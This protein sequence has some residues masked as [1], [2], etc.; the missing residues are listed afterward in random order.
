MTDDTEEAGARTELG[1]VAAAAADTRFA[2]GE[3]QSHDFRSHTDAEVDIERAT[4]EG[5]PVA[6]HDPELEGTFQA[7][8]EEGTLRLRRSLPTLLAT[9]LVGGI[10]LSI[11]VI[12]LIVVEHETGSTLLAALAFTI[13]F[14]ALTLAR[15][16]LFTE[17]FL[18]PVT[19]II[20]HQARVRE[21]ARLWIGTGAMNLVGGW[22]VMGCS[23]PRCPTLH[24]RRSGS[25]SSTRTWACPGRRSHSRS[26]AAPSSRS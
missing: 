17:N 18:V 20:A 24:R 14:I 11:G 23:S 22:L 10:D 4:G 3:G 7:A 5:R 25:P 8:V 6:E 26:S 13:G 9:G 15:G 19:A 12:A 16:E 1:E 2:A 21:L